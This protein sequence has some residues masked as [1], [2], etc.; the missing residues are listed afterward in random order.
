MS[1]CVF[2]TNPIMTVEKPK[3]TCLYWLSFKTLNLSF[4][5]FF[6]IW[7]IKSPFCVFWLMIKLATKSLSL[8][9]S[10]CLGHV[11][12]EITFDQLALFCSYNCKPQH[13][14]WWREP[15]SLSMQFHSVFFCQNLRTGSTFRHNL[16]WHHH[17]K[18]QKKKQ[19]Q[20]RSKSDCLRDPITFWGLIITGQVWVCWMLK[21]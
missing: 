4:P 15:F 8:S 9:L 21:G 10:C 11:T 12:N 2:P 17:K 18:K 3:S 13:P 16:W 1:T 14:I 5:E 20:W 19:E 7:F 6:Q